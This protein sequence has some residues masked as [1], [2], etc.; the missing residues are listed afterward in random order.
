MTEVIRMRAIEKRFPGVHALRSAEFDL[1]TGEVHA[2]MG[3]NGAGKSTLMK[4]LAGIYIPDGGSVEVNG[5]AVHFSG[6]RAAQA[7][8]IGIIHQE[9]ALMPDLTVAQNIFIGREPRNRWGV[10]DEAQLNR[11]AEAI[12]AAMKVPLDPRA[13][14]RKLTIA[15]QQ[16][17]EI[18]KALSFRSRVLIMDEPT[19]ALNEAEIAEELFAIIRRLKR[20]RR[21]HRLHQPQDGRDPPYLGSGNGDARRRLCRH[22]RR[23][24]HAHRDDH[25]HDGRP[26]VGQDRRCNS[27]PDR[28]AGGA[29]GAGVAGRALG[30]RCRL[31][32]AARRD[33]GLCRVDGGRA[34]RSGAGDLRGRSA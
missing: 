1:M 30:A 6:P 5:A 3:E 23:R 29:F 34:H 24:R 10:L 19:A 8:G 12:F 33:S 31:R 25:R 26:R 27:R 17:V 16:M 28:G 2:L 15:K 32:S 7:M 14:V 21:R 22:G 4:I 20:R 11:D 9:L 18:A 13:E